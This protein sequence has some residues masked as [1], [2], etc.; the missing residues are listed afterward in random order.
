MMFGLFK[1]KDIPANFEDY[2]SPETVNG[3]NS[4][5]YDAVQPESKN[6]SFDFTSDYKLELMTK[7]PGINVIPDN[8]SRKYLVE[9]TAARI[10]TQSIRVIIYGIVLIAIS[11]Q[12]LLISW[13]MQNMSSKYVDSRAI[14]IKETLDTYGMS[15]TSY[16][17]VKTV[18]D[19]T[20]PFSFTDQFKAITKTCVESG[21]VV[22]KMNFD[23]QAQSLS[24][25]IKNSFET[26]HSVPLSKVK[27]VG[28]W[29]VDGTFISESPESRKTNES[30]IAQTN[31]QFTEMFKST[32]LNVYVDISSKGQDRDNYNRHEL[33][34]LFW[35]PVTEI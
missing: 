22:H 6:E 23:Y 8:W 16:G 24:Q 29:Y 10:R 18:F 7:T 12:I 5:V 32:G 17:D 21:I 1:K 27:V 30:W 11:A 20:N 34:V 15:I 31:K 4:E 13:G 35:K 9:R 26:A 14:S 28:A 3:E 2:T 19:Y 33:V 25:N